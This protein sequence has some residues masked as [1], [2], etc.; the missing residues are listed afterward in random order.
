MQVRT[1]LFLE[2][3]RELLLTLGSMLSD[4]GYRVITASDAEEAFRVM[5][6]SVPDLVI[7]DIKLPGMSGLEFFTAVR[8][9]EEYNKVQFIFLTA[10]NDINAKLLAKRQGAADYI[11]KPFDFEYLVARIHQLVPPEPTEG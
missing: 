4:Q 11:T 3:E 9:S 7:A 10:F 5:K 1:I 6:Q 2:D 8:K